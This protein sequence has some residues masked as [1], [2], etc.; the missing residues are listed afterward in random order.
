MKKKVL[1]LIALILGVSAA[2]AADLYTEFERRQALP[3]SRDVRNALN[4]LRTL[5]FPVETIQ[6]I[7]ALGQGR[8]VF[9]DSTGVVCL[10][11]QPEKMLR[12]KNIIGLTT[13]EYQGDGD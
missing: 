12:C 2:Y 4:F 7:E 1:I 5:N 6:E 9:K 8:F 3:I 13:V 10:G 11:D